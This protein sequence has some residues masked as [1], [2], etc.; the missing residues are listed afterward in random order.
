MDIT[1]I[2]E[3]LPESVKADVL[4]FHDVLLKDN[5]Y[6]VRVVIDRLLTRQEKLE[7]QNTKRVLGLECVASMRSAPEIK[8]SYFY[9]VK[10]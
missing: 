2:V 3:I 6:A 9:V 7:L 5:R 10:K 4:D 1:S 8:R